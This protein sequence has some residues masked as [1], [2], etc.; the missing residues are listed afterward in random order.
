MLKKFRSGN[1]KG[2]TLIGL[3]VFVVII[4]IVAAVAIPQFMSAPDRA[5]IDAARTDVDSL[6]Q[7]LGMFKLDHGDYPPS[8]YTTVAGLAAVLVDKNGDDYM[9]LP[10]G[11]NFL[12]FSYEHDSATVRTTVYNFYRLTV[13]TLDNKGS[14]LIGYPEGTVVQ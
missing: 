12:S 11:D 7:A 4:G 6:R 13:T 14:T 9:P 2:I 1:E 10:K 5:K 3:L 8:S